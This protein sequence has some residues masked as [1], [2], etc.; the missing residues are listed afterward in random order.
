MAAIVIEC[1]RS[2]AVATSEICA[3]ENACDF[4]FKKVKHS[5]SGNNQDLGFGLKTGGEDHRLDHHSSHPSRK[6]LT[7][8]DNLVSGFSGFPPGRES[9]ARKTHHEELGQEKGTFCK[10]GFPPHVNR[11][12]CLKGSP[13]R[14][15][16]IRQSGVD[17]NPTKMKKHGVKSVSGAAASYAS[18]PRD[19]VNGGPG[20]STI[21]LKIRVIDETALI[22]TLN[23]FQKMGNGYCGIEKG[24]IKKKEKGTCNHKNIING[25]RKKN[26]G[27]EERVM[28]RKNG[29]RVERWQYK[30]KCNG[31][32]KKEEKE[33]E[34]ETKKKEK[35]KYMRVELEA[36]RYVEILE[37]RKLWKEVYDRLG[38]DVAREYEDL[39]NIKHHKNI[40]V[41]FDPTRPLI[42]GKLQ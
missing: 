2:S 42:P 9:F 33:E 40:R 23:P 24:G 32:V 25:E 36:L 1:E 41:D 3:L 39:A 21:P 38:A 37:Q 13:S 5:V 22:E 35:N 12:P 34:E 10:M 19:D 15:P 20:N 28:G 7:P 14:V 31:N 8:R 26:H 6:M 30:R 18:N 11:N 17:Q 16:R 29:V 4:S 27:R